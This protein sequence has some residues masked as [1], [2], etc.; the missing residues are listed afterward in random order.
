MKKEKFR[1][2]KVWAETNKR[3]V[4][5]DY[6]Y[7]LLDGK[8]EHGHLV[9]NDTEIVYDRRLNGNNLLPTVFGLPIEISES[10]YS[11]KA[12]LAFAEATIKP[13]GETEFKSGSL[14]IPLRK[15][16]DKKN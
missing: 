5:R 13:N 10:E 1:N 16:D 15:K 3:G 11:G 6:F 14:K 9:A 12:V 8:E 2:K 4:R 7:G